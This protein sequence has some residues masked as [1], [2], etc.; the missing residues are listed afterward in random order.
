MSVQT[1]RAQ[2]VARE[3][4]EAYYTAL[5]CN[6]EAAGTTAGVR[7]GEGGGSSV[8]LELVEAKLAAE[9]VALVGA[10]EHGHAPQ[11]EVAAAEAGAVQR[12]YLRVRVDVSHALHSTAP[13]ASGKHR[14]ST[15]T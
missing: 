13:C 11:A 15:E 5:H 8:P 6:I 4:S 14:W 1:A 12:V 2:A 7:G 9:V 3:N 10:E